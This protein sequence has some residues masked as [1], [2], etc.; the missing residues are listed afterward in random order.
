MARCESQLDELDSAILR[1]KI[2]LDKR[3]KAVGVREDMQNVKDKI[4]L[5]E[6]CARRHY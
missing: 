5:V 1:L 6:E 2:G 4:S 3:P